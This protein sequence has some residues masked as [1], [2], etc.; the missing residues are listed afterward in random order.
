MQIIPSINCQSLED[1]KKQ[2]E[3]DAGFAEWLHIDVS[4]GQ[5]TPH[6]S[7]GNPEE[8]EKFAKGNPKFEETKFEVHLMVANP[9]AVVDAWL[10]TGLV[11]RVVIHLEGMTDSVYIEEKCRK[12]GAE[13]I[14]A[15]NPGTEVE[16]LMAHTDN[17]KYFQILA[18]SPGPSGQAFNPKMVD[19][20]K[21]LRGIAPN[22]IIEVDGGVNPETA[23][24]YKDAGAELLVSGSYISSSKD[25][26]EAYVD[27]SLI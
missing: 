6:T 27:L 15:I 4:D 16:R 11:K 17:Y 3:R 2:M 14:L 9:E 18:V 13:V 7:W 8:F 19:K 1:A 5:F 21:A 20:V 24:L 25:P 12:Y 22:A 23:K 26:A 10:R